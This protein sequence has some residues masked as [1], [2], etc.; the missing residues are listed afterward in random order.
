MCEQRLCSADMPVKLLIDDGPFCPAI[1]MPAREWASRLGIA[2]DT[3]RQRRYRGD[4]WSAAFQP[5]LRRRPFNSGPFPQKQKP[6]KDTKTIAGALQMSAKLEIKIPSV[7]HI[8]ITGV[9]QPVHSA[10]MQRIQALL[11]EEFGATVSTSIPAGPVGT[12]EEV[13]KPLWVVSQA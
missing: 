9:S 12:A 8:I 1:E 5:Q 7:A 6:K 3:V 11:V 10:V 2:W 13:G 4:P